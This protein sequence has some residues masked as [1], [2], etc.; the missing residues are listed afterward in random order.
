M[1][2][3]LAKQRR[4][5]AL[6][7]RD[8]CARAKIGHSSPPL[9]VKM[10]RWSVYWE[11]VVTSF[12]PR[13]RRPWGR[14][15]A[16]SWAWTA[17]RTVS[18]I[19]KPVRRCS[20]RSTRTPNTSDPGPPPGPRPGRDAHPAARQGSER[21]RQDGGHAGRG[22]V[23]MG[24]RS[25]GQS[26]RTLAAELSERSRR[27]EHHRASATAAVRRRADSAA[28]RCRVADELA[29]NELAGP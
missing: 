14:G 18:G 15:T 4:G 10:A 7:R 28:E 22:S 6:M 21:G 26:G 9:P 25:R 13:T 3:C 12:G 27:A 20:R 16:I 5:L 17:M 29:T 11:S 24:H 19:N 23:R 2:A 1:V 8:S